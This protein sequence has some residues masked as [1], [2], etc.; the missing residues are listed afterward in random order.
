MSL[1]DYAVNDLH[2]MVGVIDISLVDLRAQILDEAHN[3]AADRKYLNAAD[4]EAVRAER[5][6]DYLL[7]VDSRS[8]E[9]CIESAGLLNVLEDA[10][11]GIVDRGHSEVM[12]IAGAI[13]LEE[14]KAVLIGLGISLRRAVG[15]VDNNGL[16]LVDLVGLRIADYL[17]VL[18]VVKGDGSE[19]VRE[20]RKRCGLDIIE[21]LAVVADMGGDI[22]V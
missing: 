6:D 10:G 13:G 12:D 8:L 2:N 9:I 1:C 20:A 18:S 15:E 22:G 17:A 14:R 11:K 7:K 5:V 21:S 16:I 3:V 19:L 4:L